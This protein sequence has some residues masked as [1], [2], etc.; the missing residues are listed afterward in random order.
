MD[1]LLG[2]E[3]KQGIPVHFRPTVACVQQVVRWWI[4]DGGLRLGC[5]HFGRAGLEDVLRDR[6]GLR[7][8]FFE[9]RG[10]GVK[11]W[12]FGLRVVCNFD[13]VA[14]LA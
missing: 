2:A 14:E 7:V 8:K 6:L 9:F 5:N 3:P 11:T 10:Q 13:E 12:L 4:R 1:S